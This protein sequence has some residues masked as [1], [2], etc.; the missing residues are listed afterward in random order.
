MAMVEKDYF[1][2]RRPH[3]YNQEGGI[4]YGDQRKPA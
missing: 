4:Y 3:I 2:I 1:Y